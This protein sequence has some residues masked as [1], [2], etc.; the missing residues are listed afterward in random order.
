[1]YFVQKQVCEFFLQTIIFFLSQTCVKYTLL[2]II[3]K[4]NVQYEAELARKAQ[5]ASLIQPVEETDNVP[6]INA[7]P[8]QQPDE[9]NVVENKEDDISNVITNQEVVTSVNEVVAPS[10]SDPQLEETTKNPA[11]KKGD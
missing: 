9:S 7:M 6:V 5:A 4:I 10:V 11:C 3:E 1:M 8:Y 2:H